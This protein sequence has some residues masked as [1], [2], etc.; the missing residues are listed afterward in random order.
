MY[1]EYF[2]LLFPPFRVPDG[3]AMTLR[4]DEGNQ[5]LQGNLLSRNKRETFHV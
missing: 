4:F 5:V 2:I 1:L 3:M